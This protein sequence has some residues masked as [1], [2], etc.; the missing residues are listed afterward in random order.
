MASLHSS[1]HSIYMLH[2]AS[3][4]NDTTLAQLVVAPSEPV[5]KTVAFVSLLSAG[6]TPPP[7]DAFKSTASLWPSKSGFINIQGGGGNFS[8]VYGSA[9]GSLFGSSKSEGAISPQKAIKPKM[10]DFASRSA[11]EMVHRG[12]A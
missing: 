2:R 5:R 12:V 3:S 10:D 8:G 9:M 6:S 7:A 4:T 11:S 1:L